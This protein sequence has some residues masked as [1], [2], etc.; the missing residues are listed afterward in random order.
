[1][2]KIIISD[3]QILPAITENKN[4]APNKWFD[5]LSVPK[6][7]NPYFK[8]YQDFFKNMTNQDIKRFILLVKKRTIHRIFLSKNGCFN[9]NNLNKI[10][11]EI[12]LKIC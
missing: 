7:N 1:M 11:I 8:E 5:N 3:Y 12:E 6:I 4:F 9:K 10:M 2:K